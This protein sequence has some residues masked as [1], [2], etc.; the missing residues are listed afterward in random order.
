MQPTGEEVRAQLER[1]LASEALAGSGRLRRFLS[2]IVERALAGVGQQ[3]KE[4]A[5][6]VE[7]FDRGDDYDPRIDSIVRVEAGRL[8]ARLD[9]YYREAGSDDAV[10]IRM[11]RGG[12]TPVFEHRPAAAVVGSSSNGSGGGQPVWSRRRVRWLAV[13]GA[14]AATVVVVTLVQW[15]GVQ[16]H[17][18]ETARGSDRHLVAKAE[19]ARSNEPA[20]SAAVAPARRRER[21][22][23]RKAAPARPPDRDRGV[24]AEAVPDVRVAVLPF[25]HYSTDPAVGL[26]AARLTDG[27][28]SE[29]VRTGRVQ[30]VSRTSTLQFASG[31]GS[32]RDVARALNANLVVEGSVHV[33]ADRVRVQMRMVD[34]DRDR[35]FSLHEFEGTGQDLDTLHRRIAAAITSMPAR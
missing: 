13:A 21:E 9:E 26:L 1:L 6:G 14:A 2:F 5:V 28:M 3:F 20:V 22:V 17:Q 16:S 29:L 32:L 19:P 15:P 30:V 25:A 18:A 11:P 8:R 7:V 34:P 12:Y 35:K 10:V 4:Y 23:P 27:V 24:E 33:D 31:R